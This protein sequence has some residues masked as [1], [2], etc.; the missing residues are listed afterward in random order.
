M[1]R[2]DL[3]Y[4]CAPVL[5]VAL[6]LRADIGTP[7]L[8]ANIL[9]LLSWALTGVIAGLTPICGPVLASMML[10]ARKEKTNV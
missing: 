3:A 4:Y 10:A 2:E 8:P 9:S 1:T 7:D 5:A 6:A